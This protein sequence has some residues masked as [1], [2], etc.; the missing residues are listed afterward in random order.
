MRV[1]YLGLEIIAVAG[2]HFGLRYLNS[3]ALNA[4]RHVYLYTTPWDN[5][6]GQ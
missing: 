5:L 4:V 3:E 1:S 6:G 2:T